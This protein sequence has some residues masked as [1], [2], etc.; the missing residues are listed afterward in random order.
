MLPKPYT[1]CSGAFTGSN[2]HVDLDALYALAHETDGM[3]RVADELTRIVNTRSCGMVLQ[4]KRTY[5]VIGGWTHG[6]DDEWSLAYHDH[7]FQCDPTVVEHFQRPADVAYVS[8]FTGDDPEFRESEF[9]QGWCQPQ[10]MHYFAG[11]YTNMPG[12]R[13]LRITL[14]RRQDQ[15]NFGPAELALMNELTPHL[16]RI[17]DSYSWFQQLALT[18]GSLQHTLNLMPQALILLDAE[19]RVVSCNVA[20]QALLGG[21]IRIMNRRVRIRPSIQAER[22]ADLIQ[23]AMESG[24]DDNEQRQGGGSLRLERDDGPPLTLLVSSFELKTGELLSPFPEKMVAV[25]I[26]DPKREIRLAD[27]SIASRFGLSPKESALVRR[28]C[29]GLTLED[30]QQQANISMYTVRDH[31]KNVF[32]K[33]GTS[34]QAELVAMVLKALAVEGGLGQEVRV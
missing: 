11:V 3:R 4:D 14:Q 21:N 9:F 26:Q 15:G 28:L 17:C 33:T 5:D 13:T 8:A 27:A 20:A 32:R 18:Q 24:K 34:R 16:R 6:I 29:E 2:M 19:A 22:L 12:D 7:F 31:L 25:F 23:K 1:C 10:G 30:I